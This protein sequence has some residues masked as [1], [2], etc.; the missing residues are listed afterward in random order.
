MAAI[1][2]ENEALV[3]FGAFA[4]VFGVMALAEIFLPRRRIENA[5]RRRWP[6]NL[7]ILVINT[8]LVRLLFPAAAVGMAIAAGE[9]GWGL[10]KVAAIPAWI[11]LPAAVLLLDLLI[12]LQHVMFHAVPLFWRFH[13]MHHSDVDFD[14][15]TGGRF[16]PAEILLSMVI[17]VGAVAAIG[18]PVA[19]VVLFE[20]VL[21]S[22]SLFNH[23]NVRI[24]SALDGVLR[25]FVVTPDMHRVHHSVVTRETNSNFG[26]NLP[27]WDRLLGTYRAQPRDGHLEMRIGLESFRSPAE[28]GLAKMLTQ[29]LRGDAAGASITDRGR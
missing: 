25:W 23:S 18:P 11:A 12:Y 2:Q 6:P 5:H 15:T 24:P 4:S 16:H 17:K 28:Y 19:A 7:G 29:P 8:L 3:R 20:I 22:M 13:R 21:S 14:V 27:W 1:M 26:F 10:L 9:R